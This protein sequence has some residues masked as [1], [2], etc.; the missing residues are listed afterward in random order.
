MAKFSELQTIM[1][2]DKKVTYL[3]DGDSYLVPTAMYPTSKP[4]E[5]Q[6]YTGY[7]NDKQQVLLS[8]GGFLIESGDRKI[9][10]DL[11]Y[12]PLDTTVPKVGRFI[13]G[14]M[15]ESLEKCGVKPEEITDVVFTHCHLDHVGWTSHDV[16]G[17]RELTFPNAAHMSSRE[18]WEYWQDD[19][20]GLGPDKVREREPLAGKMQFVKGGDE[21]IPGL[22]VIEAFGHTPGMINLM[23]T[24]S[25][26]RVYF[27][28]DLLHSDMQF[29]QA[30]WS[31]IFDVDK[32]TARKQ[33]ETAYAEMTQ[34]GTI[35][36]DG[37]FVNHAFG[38]VQRLGDKLQWS[39]LK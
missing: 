13:G 17:K 26:K 30:E 39:Y 35:I 34:P 18:E 9:L 7:L 12:G 2:D 21:I 24:G 8:L 19:T 22:R 23:L 15:L 33:R 20:S 6:Q 14:H 3:P 27:I 31:F 36:A 4:E 29:Q 32:K 11:G 1:V 28:S 25:G 16:N 38:T 5:W 10:V 37:H